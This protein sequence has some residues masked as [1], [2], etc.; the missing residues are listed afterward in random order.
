[1]SEWSDRNQRQADA[2][3]QYEHIMTT[4]A[5][6]AVGAYITPSQLERGEA[7]R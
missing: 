2:A 4:P 1:M 7:T 5:P 3:A 6:P